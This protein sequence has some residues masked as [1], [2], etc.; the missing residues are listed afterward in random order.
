MKIKQ[1][2]IEQLNEITINDL[3]AIATISNKP[4]YFIVQAISVPKLIQDSPEVLKAAANVLKIN[5]SDIYE[6]EDLP[7]TL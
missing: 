6:V 1:S 7:H 5:L 3:N 4:L 2:F